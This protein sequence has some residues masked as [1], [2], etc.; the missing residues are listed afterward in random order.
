ME[1]LLPGLLDQGAGVLIAVLLIWRLDTT[2]GRLA[3][4]LD[5][6]LSMMRELATAR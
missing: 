4:K 3:D 2:L 6:A 1:T 5:A